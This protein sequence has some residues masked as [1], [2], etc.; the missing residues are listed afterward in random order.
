MGG[1][2][3]P[4]QNPQARL[5]VGGYPPYLLF[6][7]N[8]F[9]IKKH[10]KMEN[11][12]QMK[13]FVKLQISAKGNGTLF[14]ALGLQVFISKAK[15]DSYGIKKASDVSEENPV[16]GITQKHDRITV[17]GVAIPQRE[18]VTSLFKSQQ[19]LSK[20]YVEDKLTEQIVQSDLRKA[21]AQLDLS[22]EPSQEELA[23][24]AAL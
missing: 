2:T 9:K 15:L 14:T 3:T 10:L 20:A 12:V 8:Y 11:G 5:V 13:R 22:Y 17:D 16:F 24:T 7:N 1:E 23:D 4:N 19:A 18:E 21:V 6:V